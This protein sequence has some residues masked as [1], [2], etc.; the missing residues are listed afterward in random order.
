MILAGYNMDQY[1][2]A[3]LCTFFFIVM[4]IIITNINS[5][6]YHD[7]YKIE[8]LPWNRYIYKNTSGMMALALSIFINIGIF[9]LYV[10]LPMSIS[11]SMFY[12]GVMFYR[13]SNSFMRLY[14]Y[15][16]MMRDAK[17]I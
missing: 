5:R 9:V 8:L 13:V 2:M 17:Q 16:R 1:M 10:F 12:C 14:Q 3:I 7:Y 4:D 6:L 15:W 11:F